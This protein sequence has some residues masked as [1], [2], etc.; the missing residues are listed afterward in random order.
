M[1]NLRLTIEYDGEDFQGWQKQSAA[2][3]VQEHIEH[4][5]SGLHQKPI[6]VFGASRTDSGV[7]AKAQ[8]AHFIS[9]KNLG[10][11]QW[12]A[13]LNNS[14]PNTIRV[15]EICEMPEDFHA[16]KNIRSKI[17]EYRILNRPFASAIDRRVHWYPKELDWAAIEAAMPYFIGQHDFQSFKASNSSAKTSVRTIYSFK[18]YRETADIYRFEIEGSGFLKQMIRNIIGTLILVGKGKLSGDAIPGIILSC[19]RTKAGPTAPPEG[20]T[21]VRVNYLN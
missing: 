15:T 18:L 20:L 21:L 11:Y 13:I 12:M 17:Y 7:H 2:P 1:S 4:I 14:L 8:V 10:P 3:T 5:L 6:K 9:E 16:Q 19:D